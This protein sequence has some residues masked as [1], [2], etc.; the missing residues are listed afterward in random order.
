MYWTLA[1]MIAHHASNGCSLRPGD[2]IGSGTI[3]GPE[4]ENR[5]CLLELIASGEQHAYLAD[6]DEVIFEGHCRRDG[7][8]RIG[9]GECRGVVLPGKNH[10]IVLT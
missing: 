8:R 6:G 9:F 4:K 5:G 7:F 10:R 3:S 2:L 1:Q